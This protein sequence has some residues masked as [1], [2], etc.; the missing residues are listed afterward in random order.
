M[1]GDN[2]SNPHFSRDG[3]YLVGHIGAEVENRDIWYVDLSGNRTELMATPFNEGVP[4]LTGWTVC[5][6]PIG[7]AR[8]SGGVCGC[9]SEWARPV[10]GVGEW[11]IPTHMHKGNRF[12]SRI[13]L[14]NWLRIGE[15]NSK[16]ET[17]RS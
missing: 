12:H 11:G 3:R 1:I 17:S 16:M 14:Y 15:I 13:S 7:P 2:A 10:A 5:G 6:I 4:A 9:V 8:P